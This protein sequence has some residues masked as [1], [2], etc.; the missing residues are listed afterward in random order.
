MSILVTGGSG[1]L[2]KEL[3]KILQDILVPTHQ[4]LDITDK[5]AVEEYIKNHD[6]NTIVHTAALTHIRPCE[7]NKPLA[8]KTNVEGTRNLVDAVYQNK[9]DTKFVYISTAC[10]FDG[11]VGMY[12]ESSIPY[13]ENF[14]ALTK[15]IGEYEVNKLP[16]YLII[17]TNFVA[18]KKWPY[19]KA[20]V[21]RFGTYL[22]A[23]DVAQGVRDVYKENMS[24]Y[25]HIVGDKKISMFE[26]AKMT[27][28]EIEPMTI[29][30]YSGP[31]LTMDMSL[32]TERWKKYKI[33]Q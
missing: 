16:Q 27:T 2:G 10:V 19:P 4:E 9:R 7:E 15:L 5:S 22:F 3:A 18:K 24:G 30:E 32:D 13:P 29:K 1:A 14:Y 25:V 11:H 8:W 33:S 28:P 31:R 6:I 23:Q 21:D 17:R 12:K 20:F 26:L